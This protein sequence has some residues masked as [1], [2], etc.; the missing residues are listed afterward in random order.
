MHLRSKSTKFI[1]VTV[2]ARPSYTRTGYGH[3]STA[4]PAAPGKL[5]N[6]GQRLLF[7]TCCIRFDTNIRLKLWRQFEILADKAK[8][9]GHLAVSIVNVKKALVTSRGKVAAVTT[10]TALKLVE[11]RVCFV[12]VDCKR[13]S[14]V[15]GVDD[16]EGGNK[17]E[18]GG[19]WGE[20]N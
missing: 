17:I 6:F 18:E 10:E 2:I 1:R 16:I 19:G 14:F 11:N 9:T 8:E 4:T 5:A 13:M 3:I 20:K 15:I 12:S 7:G